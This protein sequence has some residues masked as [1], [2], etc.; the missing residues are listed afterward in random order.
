MSSP[1]QLRDNSK[2]GTIGH[3][4]QQLH[5][6]LNRTGATFASQ[7]A[8]QR[9][10]SMEN[11]SDT[12]SGEFR[13][14]LE[15]LQLAVGDIAKSYD[16]GKGKYKVATESGEEMRFSS[17]TTDAQ[18]FA[19]MVAGMLAADV[20]SFLNR[21]VLQQPAMEEN[22][23]FIP[24]SGADMLE[25]RVHALEAYDEREN[26]ETTV[27]SVAYNMQ[28]ATQDEFGEALFPTCIVTPDQYGLTISMRLIM[29]MDDLRR[30]ASGQAIRDFQRK[31][32]IR[33]AID[34]A[35]LRND[36]TKI[37]PVV[38]DAG[39]AL[40]NFV[41]A[42]LVPPQTIVFEGQSIETAPL[43][44]GAQFDLLGISQTEA[45]LATGTLDTTDAIDPNIVLGAL[46]MT[47]QG[48]PS[49]GSA[50]VTEVIKFGNVSL[51]QGSTFTAAPQ[52]NYRQQMLNFVTDSLPINKNTV[53]N[54]GA[55]SQLIT[56]IV[57]AGA[58]VKLAVT[59]GGNVNLQTAE[60]S[61]WSGKVQVAEVRDAN[62]NILDPTTGTGLAYAQLFQGATIFGYDLDARRVN[63]N[64]R[65][66][67]QLLDITYQNV[68]YGVPL[69]SP[70]T[71]PRPPAGPQQDEANYLAGLITATRVRTSNA[72]VAR[73]LEAEEALAAFVTTNL[74]D[75]QFVKPEILGVGGWLVQPQYL[76]EDY[77]APLVVDSIKSYERAADIQASLVNM[78]RE[79][80]YRMYRDSGYKAAANAMHGGIA[81]MPTVII[82]TDTYIASYLQVTGDFRTL[83][84]EFNVKVV[85]T[86]NK[87]MKGKIR[88]TFGE[89]GEGK[90]NTPN[91]LHF[92]VMAWKPELTLI[93]PTV[94]N[95][96]NSREISVSPS[97]RHI[98][99]LP[100]M[101]SIDVTGIDEVVNAKV[102]VNFHTV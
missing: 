98:V 41:D 2:A 61:I 19:G 99:N 79:M 83:G 59:V 49:G 33:A 13:T 73:L 53:L 90:E 37:F 11:L 74:G 4:V 52:G 40:G 63:T 30:N 69:L 64:R 91:P 10:I 54:D 84:N 57:T 26:K 92:G 12:Q 50:A 29:V 1:F 5:T 7:A 66:R 34:P 15:A 16:E 14:S 76:Q 38:T 22:Q 89:F 85:S 82:A 47:I 35:V 18:K 45:L 9:V 28:A 102:A 68:I 25:K 21:S 31:N 56:P 36:L 27:Y 93:L 48:T 67:G 97:F 71:A 43:A 101:A 51:M 75:D 81:P 100:I 65:E 23:H 78:I 96:S 6:A 87:L 77:A 58:Q 88:I 8:V 32:I 62:N 17:V 60:T 24:A 20:P 42:T 39:V 70:I 95:G 55:A 72:A 3:M 44:I 94:R 86:T 80:A 46:Y